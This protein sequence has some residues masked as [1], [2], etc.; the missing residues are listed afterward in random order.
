[1]HPSTNH[2]EL[3]AQCA[4]AQTFEQLVTIAIRE[5]RRFENGCHIV[6]GPISTG[7]RGTAAENL[8]VFSGT[9]A[10]LRSVPHPVFDQTPYEA[11]LAEFHR[12]WVA[13]DPTTRTGKY[14]TDILT[15]F[16]LPLFESGA[17]VQSWFIPDWETSYSATWERE[18]LQRHSIATTDLNGMWM[19]DFV[20]IS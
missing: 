16:Y 17:I 10:A 7:G 5:A 14:C 6:C 13:E 8:K 3:L 2:A 12:R 4:A 15:Q 18:T 1:M 20:V 11:Q 9:I 19:D